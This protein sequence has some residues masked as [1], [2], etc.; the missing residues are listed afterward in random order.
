MAE[1]GGFSSFD[2][3]GY[4]SYHAGSTL[5]TSGVVMNFTVLINSIPLFLTDATNSLRTVFILK[6]TFA[7]YGFSCM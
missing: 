2:M 4:S 1:R 5:S 3:Q 6:N 7:F